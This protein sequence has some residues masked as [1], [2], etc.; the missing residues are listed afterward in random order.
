VVAVFISVEVVAVSLCWLEAQAIRLKERVK[1]L[2]MF[3]IYD[4]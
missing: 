3:S 1:I 2:I 4:E